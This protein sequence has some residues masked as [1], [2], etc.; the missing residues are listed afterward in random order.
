MQKHGQG[1]LQGNGA[2][3]RSQGFQHHQGLCVHI[4]FRMPLGGLSAADHSVYFRDDVLHES[5]FHQHFHPCPPAW[6]Q[7]YPVQL[8]PD[9]LRGYPG[10]Q[11]GVPANR[12][13]RFLFHDN[14]PGDGKAHRPHQAQGIF[15]KAAVRIPDRPQNPR[16]NVRHAIHIIHDASG[17]V[18]KR[19]LKQAVH[20]EVTAPGVFTR[21][22]EIDGIRTAAV[23]VI[24]VPP[25]RGYLKTEALVKNQHYAE[26]G[27]H[28]P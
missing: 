20:R 9:A 5:R 11:T 17:R 2:S 7:Q 3:V 16:L 12:S 24:S 15:L 1:Q 18:G 26:G 27:A 28:L 4:P 8:L 23:A 19:F 25:E 13:V 21:I 14:F 6:S 10:Q 22:R